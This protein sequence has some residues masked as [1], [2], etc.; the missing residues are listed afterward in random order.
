[1]IPCASLCVIEIELARNHQA[2]VGLYDKANEV[3]H[4]RMATSGNRSKRLGAENE[5]VRLDH[6]AAESAYTAKDDH[7][8]T[9]SP[10]FSSVTKLLLIS[11]NLTT[12]RLSSVMWLTSEQ[13]PG[14]T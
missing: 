4:H 7:P 12:G 13:T 2:D 9:L 5:A 3:G 14:R 8:E 1:V 6:R 11:S 10:A